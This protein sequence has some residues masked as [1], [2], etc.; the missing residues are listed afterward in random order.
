MWVGRLREVM[1]VLHSKWPALAVFTLRA[2]GSEA[3][4][5]DKDMSS[6]KF[7]LFT[8]VR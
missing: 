8:N 1:S 7:G 3:S 5:C 4:A 2:S 6:K